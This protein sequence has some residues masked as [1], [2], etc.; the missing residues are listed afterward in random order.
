MRVIFEFDSPNEIVLP[1]HH[2][3]IVQGLIY[4]LF[5]DKSFA[6]FL[7]NEGYKW[8]KRKF[9]LFSFSRLMGNF[10]IEKQ[11]KLIIFKSPI[12]LVIT[13]CKE[14]I[15]KNLASTVIMKNTIRLGKQD[16]CLKEMR[17]QDFDIVNEKVCINML[18]PVVTYRTDEIDNKKKTYYYSPW[19]AE[20]EEQIRRNLLKKYEIIARREA[21]SKSFKIKPLFREGSSKPNII[22]YR[23]YIIKGWSGKFE[24]SGDMELIKLAYDTGLGSKNSLGH[25]CFE[26]IK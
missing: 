20:F 9:K 26:I 4:N 15:I 21:L 24:I 3:H 25:G 12:K 1:I 2:N 14:E 18:S 19:E 22:Y 6:E 11:K 5:S 16:V 8:N 13:S 17:F 10:K 7:H 23:N